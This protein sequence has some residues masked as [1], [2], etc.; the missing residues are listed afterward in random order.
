MGEMVMSF[1]E[2]INLDTA[3]FILALQTIMARW[4]K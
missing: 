1:E 3:V 2:K 4:T